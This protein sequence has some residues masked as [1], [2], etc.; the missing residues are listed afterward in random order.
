MRQEL[1]DHEIQS[2]ALMQQ[3]QNELD[4]AQHSIENLQQLLNEAKENLLKQEDNQKQDFENL[5]NQ[6]NLERNNFIEKI[7]A[8]TKVIIKKSKS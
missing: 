7:N 5:N 1:R 8:L 4:L 2:Q 6:W 3:Y